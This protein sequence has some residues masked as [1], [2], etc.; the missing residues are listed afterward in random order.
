MA[1]K[2]RRLQQV[3]TPASE[4]NTANRYQDP[5]QKNINAKLDV[6]GKRFEGKGRT[7]MYGIAALVV[8][9]ILFLIVS[10]YNR[11][12]DGAAQAAL[13]KAIEI[14]QSR[15]SDT[16][17]PAGSTEK[18]YKSEKERA[19]AA[20]AE[21][22]I[23][24]DK[25]GGSVGEKA[26]Y[27]IAV[28]KLMSDRTAGITELEGFSKTSTDTGKLAKF[29]LAQTRAD[30]GKLD[31]AVTL[32]QELI[33]MRDALVAKDTLNFELAKIYQKQ[34]KTKEAADI[35]YAIAKTA[36]DAKDTDGK[37]IPLTETARD[38]KEKLTQLDS[39]RAKEIVEAPP[40]S[41]FGN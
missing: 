30:D 1:R 18:I 8:I 36:S 11:R 31:E 19:D 17:A 7:I 39:E 26:K 22:Q 13:G 23:V 38:A 3:A 25:F 12:S 21:F 32:Y 6:V 10:A 28:N 2:Q 29:A 24:A 34:N 41:P 16:P 20:I 40:E 15:V 14:S 37:A 27:F 4:P 35:Y 9:V 5:L 33:A